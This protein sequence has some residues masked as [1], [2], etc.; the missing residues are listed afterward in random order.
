MLPER[1][2]HK[3]RKTFGTGAFTVSF[4]DA[5][6]VAAVMCGA[7]FEQH[8]QQGGKEQALPQKSAFV[9]APIICELPVALEASW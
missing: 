1:E 9:H 5:D 7:G 4:A 3:R 8:F 2:G 6:H